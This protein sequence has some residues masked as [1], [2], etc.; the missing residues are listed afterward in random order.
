MLARRQA[1]RE[2]MS[3]D[4]FKKELEGLINRY[5][6]ERGSNTPDF[7]LADYLYG[8]LLQFNETV[9]AREKWYKPAPAQEPKPCPGCGHP[10]HSVL[11][12]AVKNDKGVATCECSQYMKI[13]PVAPAPGEGKP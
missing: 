12:W 9:A 11:C 4:Q 3:N 8:C 1:G 13:A 7:I 6:M 2:A 10:P 5:S